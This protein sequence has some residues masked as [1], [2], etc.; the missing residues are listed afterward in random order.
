MPGQFIALGILGK[1]KRDIITRPGYRV[2]PIERSITGNS[3]G[4]NTHTHTLKDAAFSIRMCVVVVCMPATPAQG[5][6]T[7]K[8]QPWNWEE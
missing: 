3:S 6:K 4:K 1:R 2:S 8:E 5:Q 7:Q